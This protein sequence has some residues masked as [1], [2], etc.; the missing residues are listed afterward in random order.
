MEVKE[1]VLMVFII[2]VVVYLLINA[3]SKTTQ[4][5]KMAP[6][7]VAQTISADKMKNVN[8]SSNFTYS[9]W[10]YVDDW[11]YL[12]GEKK[13]VLDRANSPTVLLGDKP[14]TL[15]VHMNYFNN[16]STSVTGRGSSRGAAAA[17]VGPT[18]AQAAVCQKAADA[19][20]AGYACACAVCGANGIPLADGPGQT[21]QGGA[22]TLAARRAANNTSVNT[23]L[24]E[25]IPIQKWFNVIVSLYGLTLDIY[26]D[27]K[28]VR[29]CVMP[30]VPKVD[31]AANINVTNNGGFSGWTTK[32]Q[33]WSDASNP[34]QAYN[35]YK[36]GFGGSILGNA[37]SKYRVQV[38]MLKDNV[39]K[40]S[41]Q[42]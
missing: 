26:L 17:N 36:A 38:S 21:G 5:T 34:Q 2:L 29:T 24:I 13:T 1:I 40:G 16:G 19:C 22:G 39:Q 7:K 9:M 11:N 41:F 12:F 14:N 10:L 23:C 4:L 18:D 27:G 3:F 25:N 42:I 8:N 15:M 33:F 37:V 31:N 20:A 32:F 30:G 6:A 35:I 28:L